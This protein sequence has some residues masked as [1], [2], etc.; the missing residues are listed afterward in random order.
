MEQLDRDYDDDKADEY[1][2]EVPSYDEFRSRV[3]CGPLF[4]DFKVVAVDCGG[5][6]SAGIVEPLYSLRK[7]LKSQP[8]GGHIEGGQ[9]KRELAQHRLFLSH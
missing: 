4:D 9:L 5:Y 2:Y 7:P 3:L 8:G 1:F 6:H